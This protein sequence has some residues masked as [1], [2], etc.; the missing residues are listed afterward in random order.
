VTYPALAASPRTITI[1][2]R[3]PRSRISSIFFYG[4]FGLL[5][6]GPLAFGEAAPWGIFILEVGAGLLFVVWVFQQ[7]S[8]GTL[9]IYS[10]PIFLPM[11]A[12]AGLILFQLASG[13]TSYR[14]ATFSQ[15]LLYGS[16]GLLCFL[17]VQNLRHTWQ[18]Q[19]M[20]WGFSVYG[21]LLA[22][23][24]LLQSI[25]S[26]QKIYWLW[27]SHLGSRPYGPYVNSNHYAGLMEM[28]FPIPLI[29]SLTR[30][31]SG[32]SRASA[33]FAAAIM[34]TSIFLS[35]S[36]G[37]MLAVIGQLVFFAIILA[38]R[39]KKTRVALT[40]GAFAIIVLGL[41]FWLGGAELTERMASLHSEAGI[42]LSGATRLN[43]D[44]DAFRMFLHK[45]V[46]GFGLGTFSDVFP[47]FRSFY[48]DLI[49][50]QAHNDYLQLLVET[51]ILGFVAML[52]FLITVC[53]RAFINLSNWAEDK[54]GAVALA[55]F[56]GITGILVHSC[57]DFNLHIPANAA[58]FFVLCTIAT[59]EPRFGLARRRLNNQI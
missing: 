38:K 6:F 26:P 43:I 35:G 49:V 51:G 42:D 10:N 7:T 25:T 40:I 41:L 16:Y 47:Q 5:L 9:E 19:T 56:L 39:K 29:F 58:L 59:M 4:I 45:P 3:T 31:A 46:L 14:Y 17:V 54:N 36:R 57:V 33:V 53:R 50:D 12:F 22:I 28:L 20:T 21:S 15:A 8:S 30:Y 37:G 11:L 18:I 52:W 23:F 2:H 24:A 34:A 13:F 48:T 32:K 44:R 55:A 27:N 1:Q